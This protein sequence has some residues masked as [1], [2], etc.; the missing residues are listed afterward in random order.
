MNPGPDMTATALTMMAALAVL[1]GG[2]WLVLH[3]VRRFSAR[4]GAGTGRKTVRV[5]ASAYVGVKKNVTLVAV[6]GSVLVLGVT[7]D[8]ISLLQTIEDKGLR[9]Q[10]TGTDAAGPPPSFTS[11]LQRLARR[12]REGD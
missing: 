10:I 11:Q 3:A 4:G 8:R 9:A 6:P 2:L 5:L 12:H 7:Q 1:L